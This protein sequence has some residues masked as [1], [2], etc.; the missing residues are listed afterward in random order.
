MGGFTATNGTVVVAYTVPSDVISI[1]IVATYKSHQGAITS[2]DPKVVVAIDTWLIEL[3]KW[4]PIIFLIVIIVMAI[5]FGV[6]AY[7]KV[8]R[9]RFTSIED[10][11]RQ[12]VQ[13]RAENRREIAQIT[14]DIQQQREEAL[15]EADVAVQAMDFDKAAK[16]Y[17]K[18]GNFTLELADKAVAKEFFSKAKQ[19]QEKS[20]QKERQGELKE[21]REKLLE[22]A[23]VAIRERNVVEASRNYRQV[24]EMSRMLGEREQAEKF[25]KLANVA[26]ERIIALKEGDMRKK[27]GVF[28]SKADKSMG[29]QD[30]LGAADNF[31]EAAKIMLM[32]GDEEGTLR[33]VNWAKLARERQ[34]LATAKSRDDWVQALTQEQADLIHKAKDFIRERKYDDAVK[35][36]TTLTIYAM[37]L[38]KSD[39]TEKYKKDVD[40]YRKQAAQVEISPES[41]DLIEERRKLLLN[42]EDAIKNNR[43]AVAAKYYNRIATI[44]EIAEG[45][46]VARNYLKQATYYASKGQE[47]R[48][49]EKEEGEEVRPID[50]MP[51]ARVSEEAGEDIGKSKA[52]LA[53][54]VK[55]AR[56]ALKTGKPVLARDLYEKAATKAE[57]IEDRDSAL[58]YK[59]KAEEIE[60]VK[61][62]KVIEDEGTIR[63]KLTDLT[64]KAEKALQKKKYAEVKNLYEEISELFLRIGEEDAANSFLERASSL[65]RLI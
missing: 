52:E 62:K 65:K 38:G 25:L 26:N 18:A 21:Q 3:G 48:L 13:K 29:K 6:A 51:V 46:E 34:S 64:A 28:L 8:V 58:R 2:S 45:K 42:V 30:F 24:A 20:Q 55:Q 19:M 56:D 35:S 47:K 10:R 59:Q 61:P 41:R 53:V 63:R 17:E 9:P 22:A 31:E 40:F 11:K 33:F 16:F 32:L 57:T 1:Y 43:Y 14:G 50:R 37:E 12:L 49:K 39:L 27:S 4:L 23:R 54:T 44:T 15:K 36:Y 7:Y 5:I 60:I